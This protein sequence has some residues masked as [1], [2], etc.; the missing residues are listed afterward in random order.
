MG[1]VKMKHVNIYGPKKSPKPVLEILARVA[2]FHPD[3]TAAQINA[4]AGATDNVYEPLFVQ[5]EG[6]LKDVGADTT[7]HAWEGVPKFTYKEAKNQ[8]EEYAQRIAARG[9]A[10]TEA[11]AK[12]ATFEQTKLQLYHLTNLHTSIDE[13]FSCK[14][15]KVRFGRLPEDS[16]IKLPFYAD[17]P[18]TFNEYDFDGKYYWGMYFVPEDH[19]VEV[20][21][22]F[23]SLYF[24]RMWVPDFVHG[25]PQDALAQLM[26]EESDVRKSLEQLENLSDIVSGEDAAM[27]QK[28]ASWLNYESQIYDMQKYVISLERSYY[29]SGFVPENELDKLKEALSLIPEVKAAEDDTESLADA[30]VH[31]PVKLKN[32]W[33]ARPFEMFVEMYG[34]PG[35]GDLD[36]TGFVAITYAVLFGV[37][38]GDV[39]QGILLGIIGY[40]FMYKK[41]HLALGLILTRCSFFSVVFGFLYGSVF[42]FEHWLDGFWRALGLAEK[43]LEVMSPESTNFILIGSI[44]AGIFIIAAAIVTGILSNFKRGIYAKTIFSVNGLA[45]LIFYISIILAFVP[46]LTGIAVPFIGTMPFYILCLAIPFVCI[47]FAEPICQLIEHEKIHEGFGEIFTNGFFEMFDA[48]L[49][50]ASNTMSFLRVGGF[51]L[52]HA[53]MMSVVFTLADMVGGGPAYW[54]IVVIGNLFVMGLEALFVGIQVL[55]LEFYEVFSRFFEASGEP[56]TP[57]TVSL[58]RGAEKQ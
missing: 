56:Y 21:S 2:C 19:S 6:V 58:T 43:P 45:G 29:I 27:L 18:F 48:L 37:M 8:I 42:G 46:M 28:M 38:F 3:T 12:L 49:S 54:I 57:L 15:L 50:F 9:L 31:P 39:G 13:I 23:S 51:V 36:P 30:E 52:A 24:E 1:M 16:Y 53:G 10:K 5:L 4:A 22:I 14:Y 35:Y 41:M 47:F 34:L 33:F 7:L 40:F 11:E 25:T 20:D 44:V 17:K 26:T 55:R 32:N